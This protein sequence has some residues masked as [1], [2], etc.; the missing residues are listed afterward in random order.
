MLAVEAS[1]PKAV[2]REAT[3]AAS[4][5]WVIIIAGSPSLVLH[6]EETDSSPWERMQKAVE[7][8]WSGNPRERLEA[9][10]NAGE[11]FWPLE[12]Q[13]QESEPRGREI[14]E[15]LRMW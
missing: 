3:V 14:V 6:A 15:S 4:L 10:A 13:H 1:G 8:L 2:G 12:Y 11:V 5:V 9:A 7:F